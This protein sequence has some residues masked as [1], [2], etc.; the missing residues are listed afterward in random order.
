M[1]YDKGTPLDNLWGFVDGTVGAISRPGIHQR[2]LYNGHKRYHALK[3]QS[4]VAPNGLV[5]NL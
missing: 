5:A 1:V 4:V 2:V 3:F